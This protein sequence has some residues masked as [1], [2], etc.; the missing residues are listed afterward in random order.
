MGGGPDG[1]IGGWI[2]DVLEGARKQ[3]EKEQAA[4]NLANARKLLDIA[5]E[6]KRKPLI[7]R[8]DKLTASVVNMVELSDP[9][10]PSTLLRRSL[11]TPN[12][13]N[14]LKFQAELN[15]EIEAL[16]QAIA[17]ADMGTYDEKGELMLNHE[18]MKAFEHR[19]QELTR[20]WEI[21]KNEISPS[22]QLENPNSENFE[23]KKHGREIVMVD[24]NSPKRKFTVRAS[25][26]VRFADAGGGLLVVKGPLGFA[27]EAELIIGADGKVTARELI[28][29]VFERAGYQI[30]LRQNAKGRLVILSLGER[31]QEKVEENAAPVTM[32]NVGKPFNQGRLVSVESP[33]GKKAS[34]S[35]RLGRLKFGPNG[36][37]GID[38]NAPDRK[39][40]TLRLAVDDAG[41]LQWKTEGGTEENFW[42]DYQVVE[43]AVGGVQVLTVAKK[44]KV[45]A[46]EMPEAEVAAP[47]VAEKATEVETDY[48][49]ENEITTRA[50]RVVVDMSVKG[51][52]LMTVT[53]GKNGKVTESARGKQYVHVRVGKYEGDVLMV[54]PNPKDKQNPCKCEIVDGTL[55]EHYKFA[56]APTGDKTLFV[57]KFTPKKK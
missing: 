8:V 24:P 27:A 25:G 38:I 40:G 2:P 10:R 1:G 51:K 21:F 4:Q 33:N 48:E 6:N 7:K 42:D 56:T 32:V 15:K 11:S 28:Q 23:I 3:A 30:N 14:L 18:A 39:V 52:R 57:A 34:F 5:W 43:S 13:E 46:P 53:F 47:V 20:K 49:G 19:A 50:G 12:R 17:V 44:Q 35:L 9:G 31:K 16:Y 26:N 22:N 29:D 41:Q 37:D 36:T 45:K 54:D 55:K